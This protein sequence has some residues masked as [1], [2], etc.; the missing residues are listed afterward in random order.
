[1][2]EHKMILSDLIGSD[3]SLFL[4]RDGVINRRIEG[5][6]VRRWNQFEFLPGV[7]E[8]MNKI[9]TVFRRILIVS[10]QQGI[11]KGLMTDENV[12]QIHMQMQKEIEIAGGRIDAVL[13]CGDS[14]D[15]QSFFRKPNIGMA[16]Q[17]RKLF[18]EIRFKKS[19]MVGDSLSD[20]IFGKKLGMK[21]VFLSADLLRIRRAHKTINYVYED[22]KTFAEYL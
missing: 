7:L 8:S 1:M 14:S 12:Q 13:Y 22:L 4:D 18:P 20:M 17:A 5:D 19:I 2:K 21:T 11:S 6:Y 3:W 16:L 10:N 15:D 9:A